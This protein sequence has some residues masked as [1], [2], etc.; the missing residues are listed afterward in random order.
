M[1]Q[2]EHFLQAYGTNNKQTS[3]QCLHCIVEYGYKSKITIR[4]N[5]NT[6]KNQ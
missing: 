2:N 3:Q 5:N 1:L 4:G 6:Q